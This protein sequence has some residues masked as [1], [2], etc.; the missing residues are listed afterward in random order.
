MSSDEEEGDETLDEFNRGLRRGDR[1][2]TM[3]GRNVNPRGYGKRQSY[4]VKAEIPNFAR[5]LNIGTVLDWLY[6]ELGGNVNKITEE[7]KDLRDLPAGIMD[8]GT[9]EVKGETREVKESFKIIKEKLTTA[10]VLSLP[11]FNRVFELECDACG[12][13]IG[14]ILSQE[15]RP[16]VIHS[17]CLC[18]PKTSLRIQLIKERCVM[19]QEG[20]GKAQCI[21]LY[22]LLPIPESSWVDILMGFVLGLPRTQ[23]GVDYVFVVVVDR[24]SK[25][26]YFIPCNKT[27]DAEHIAR[28]F[29]HE[30]VRLHGVPKSITSNRI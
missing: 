22:M 5:N 15:G 18:I 28:L 12:N 14:A 3:V 17:N 23:R 25:M 11:N 8:K 27:L 29:F 4:R 13:R 20:K 10:P 6:E 30:V 19:C 24:F 21:G 1:H 7:H 16:V 26:A 9:W 2:R